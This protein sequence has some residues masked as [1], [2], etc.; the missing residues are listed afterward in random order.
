M[1]VP[2]A[3][4]VYEQIWGWS[5]LG[6]AI[7]AL[8]ALGVA[9]W[10]IVEAR[11]AA[12]DAKA[13]AA[14]AERTADA[15]ERTA[16]AAEEEARVSTRLL[17][18][19]EVDVARIAEFEVFLQVHVLPPQSHRPMAV[20]QVGVRNV[21]SRDAPGADVNIVVPP[22]VLVEPCDT[23]SGEGGRRVAMHDA[24]ESL[25]KG[26]PP[27]PA[28]YISHP[29]NLQVGANVVRFYRLSLPAV[30]IIYPVRVAVGHGRAKGGGT[31]EFATVVA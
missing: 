24:R 22:N 26:A 21:G 25:S 3:H 28:K 2:L 30:G 17:E 8:V 18:I 10:S 11:R 27:T 4:D 14:A 1:C 7:L 29:L 31:V 19:T 23:V 6:G 20:L 12:R 16:A 15:A 13:A 9:A 5:Q